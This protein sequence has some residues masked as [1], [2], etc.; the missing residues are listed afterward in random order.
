MRPLALHQRVRR[1]DPAE[2]LELR[3]PLVALGELGGAAEVPPRHHIREG[4]VVDGLVVLV[5]PDDPV[6]VRVPG[7]VPADPRLPVP[8]GL[9]EQVEEVLGVLLGVVDLAS[10][11]PHPLLGDATD[12]LL[13]LDQLQRKL[14]VH[15]SEA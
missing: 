5:G 12:G 11:R 9:D 7:A 10:T 1:L 13:E 2:D 4:V 14:E 3:D 6:Q 15:G 8:G